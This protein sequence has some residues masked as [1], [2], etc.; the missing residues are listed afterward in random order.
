MN[1]K[2]H[3]QSFGKNTKIGCDLV[4]GKL[5]YA[6]CLAKRIA[7]WKKK[8][9]SENQDYLTGYMSGLSVVEGMLAGMPAIPA[10]P[11]EWLEWRIE[12][13]EREGFVEVV[14]MLQTVRDWWND[15]RDIW[16]DEKEQEAQDG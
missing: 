9:K 3:K 13:A 14:K 16:R 10:I 4:D 2:K 11:V 8:L 5:I 6:G 7:E 15:Q 1:L 12:H